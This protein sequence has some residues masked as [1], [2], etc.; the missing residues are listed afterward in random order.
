M[1]NLHKCAMYTVKA[2]RIFVQHQTLTFYMQDNF[3]FVS[4]YF[5][6]NNFQ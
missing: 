1:L 4:E 2:Q 5:L 6:H 3:L